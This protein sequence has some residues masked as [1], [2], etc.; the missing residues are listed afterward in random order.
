MGSAKPLHSK[1]NS[2]SGISMSSLNSRFASTRPKNPARDLSSSSNGS[3][4]SV[5][6]IGGYKMVPSISLKI[7]AKSPKSS[8]SPSISKALKGT[9]QTKISP[10][11]SKIAISKK[12]VFSPKSSGS[13]S[14]K[15]PIASSNI[16]QPK[17]KSSV[18]VVPKRKV[19][20][21]LGV[22]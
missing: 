18:P 13:S 19:N 3:I 1:A 4:E 20:I 8:V 10:K 14:I 5:R 17:K 7:D 2:I 9:S 16:N 11:N 6:L 15:L 22:T 21:S 12:P